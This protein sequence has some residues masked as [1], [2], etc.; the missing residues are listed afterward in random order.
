MMGADLAP[1]FRQLGCYEE[2]LKIGKPIAKMTYF[3]ENLKP[4]SVM[5]YSEA[6]RL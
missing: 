3:N 5:D 6:Q 1:L 4:L 2:F